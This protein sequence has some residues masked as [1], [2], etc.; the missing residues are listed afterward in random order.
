MSRAISSSIWY[1]YF[2]EN[3]FSRSQGERFRNEC[4][5]FGGGVPSRQLCENFLQEKI[6]ADY[7]SQSLVNEVDRNNEKIEKL[8]RELRTQGN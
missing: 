5:A 6:T 4:L 1:N 8:S 2:D 3:P 7:L